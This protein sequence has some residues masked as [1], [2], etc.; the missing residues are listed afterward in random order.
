MKKFLTGFWFSFPVQLLLLHFRRTQFLMLF[1]VLIIA[2]ATKNFG[3]KFGVPYLL[4]DPEYLGKVNFFSFFILGACAGAF[5]LTFNM[6]S[7]ILHSHRF[8]FLATF[9]KP[10]LRYSLNNSIIPLAAILIILISAFGFQL[11][12]EYSGVRDAFIRCG[13]F[14]C[15]VSLLP[16]LSFVKFLNTHH[17]FTVEKGRR[18]HVAHRVII[19]LKTKNIRKPLRV[20][21][22]LSHPFKIRHVRMV[23]HYDEEMLLSVF[24]KHH[25]NALFLEVIGM[26]IVIALGFLMEYRLFRIPAGASIFLL[27]S[28]LMAPIGA[29]TFWL[30]SW[31]TSVFLLL[32]FLINWGMKFDF[33]SSKNQAYGM[34][35]DGKKKAYTLGNILLQSSD[36]FFRR[37]YRRGIA[38][39]ENWKTKVTAGLDSNQRRKKP[40][41]IL[42]N[43]SG[44]GFRSAIFSMRVMQLCDS[45]TNMEFTGHAELISGASGGMIGAAFYRELF[46]EKLSGKKVD[47]YSQNQVAAISR[48]VLNAV[49]ISVAVNDMFYPWQ[50]FSVN[51]RSYKKDRAYMFEKILNENTGGILDKPISAYTLPEQEGIIPMMI[52]TPTIINDARCLLVSSQ[53]VAYLTKPSGITLPSQDIKTDAVNFQDFFSEQDAKNLRF[54]SAIRMNCTFPYILPNVFLPTNPAVQ[55][56][57]AGLRDN[58]GMETSLR[59]ISVFS[60]WLNENVGKI[61]VVQ[62]RDLDKT[63]DQ[64]IPEPQSMI[65]KVFD[66]IG[67]IYKQ[68]S[69]FQDYSEQQ[70]FDFCSGWLK[71]PLR[72]FRFEY[73]PSNYNEPA[74]MNFHLTTREKQDVLNSVLRPE[75]Q[76]ALTELTDMINREN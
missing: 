4:L 71:V 59:F 63:I 42:I 16:F 11:K 37:D 62:M 8:P 9:R 12:Y 17:E 70:A 73:I 35:Y 60:D 22:M 72:L 21:F 46:L 27:C 26:V 34:N 68:W 14:L 18:K 33:N 30:K 15:G 56:M 44:G 3:I 29:F 66:P 65:S 49:C 45:L 40:T 39:L 41:M 31:A 1:W 58:F 13:G 5:I 76:R 75:N 23:T 20:D 51:N 69:V 28:I 57:D 50:N 10:F 36:T 25:L 64:E 38:M 52:F 2:I 19:P 67:S 61:V 48:D 24:R 53:S 74:S 55:V 6:T 43:A 47:L 7:Y 32:I 54:T